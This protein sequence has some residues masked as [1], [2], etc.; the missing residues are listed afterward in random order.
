MKKL[1]IGYLYPELMNTYGDS[2]NIL[3][4]VKRCQ[5]RKISVEI[6]NISI[7]GKIPKEVNLI[8]FGGGQDREQILVAKDLRKKAKDI[9]EFV[10][11]NLP[12]LAVCGGYQL[13]G[14]FYKDQD[15]NVLPGIGLLNIETF[16]GNRRMIGNVVIKSRIS[17]LIPQI[18]SK[19][20]IPEN[21]I[22][23]VGFENHSGKTYLGEGMK[24]L[25]KVITGYGNN[26]EDG[27]EGCIYKNAIGTYLH[28]SLLPK[29]PQLC[30]L[31]IK[32]ALKVETLTQ[33]ND[34]IETQAH[35]YL[36][37]RFLK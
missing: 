20:Q 7:G 25:G 5:W 36:V 29:N 4:L 26:G 11:K 2:G 10:E 14:K 30:D 21:E 1:I 23:L 37:E 35:N 3:A 19:F 27:L 33:I 6:K 17:D 16:A 28:G 24:P 34:M 22:I 31:L 15:G 9:K 13:L 18:N 8:F 32:K 12:L